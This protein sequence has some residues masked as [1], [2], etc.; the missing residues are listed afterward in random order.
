[1]SNQL[2]SL[3]SAQGAKGEKGARGEAGAPG[4]TVSNCF[5]C[6]IFPWQ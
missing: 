4:E 1:M 6:S 5:P 2:V 3:L